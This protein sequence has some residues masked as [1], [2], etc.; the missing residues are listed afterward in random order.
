MA[1]TRTLQYLG[2]SLIVN[3]GRM[4]GTLTA[5]SSE[6][7]FRIQRYICVIRLFRNLPG[8]FFHRA[9]E[10]ISFPNLEPL[11]FGAVRVLLHEFSCI[12]A[13][14]KH[15]E[16]SQIWNMITSDVWIWL[17]FLLRWYVAASCNVPPSSMLALFM[18]P[19]SIAFPITHRVGRF[20]LILGILGA[21]R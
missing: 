15:M 5:L 4:K 17:D 3:E 1:N 9:S 14:I 7:L 6:V 19:F 20:H 18:W 8:S 13:L 11:V 21:K 16:S 12:E 2:T 10:Y